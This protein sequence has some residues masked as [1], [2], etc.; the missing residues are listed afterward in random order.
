MKYLPFTSIHF[1]KVT[2]E[3]ERQSGN[4]GITAWSFL[5]G[6]RRVRQP[7]GLWVRKE[8]SIENSRDPNNRK[9]LQITK[10][11]PSNFLH[12]RDASARVI[13]AMLALL[14]YSGFEGSR[15]SNGHSLCVRDVVSKKSSL[16]YVKLR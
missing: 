12:S 14:S 16:P 13:V 4:S 2:G 8:K 15:A 10:F 7:A 1:S 6:L 9:S 3:V 11:K 5:A